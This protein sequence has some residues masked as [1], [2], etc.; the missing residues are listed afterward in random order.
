MEGMNLDSYYD[1]I[2]QIKNR[3]MNKQRDYTQQVVSKYG[4]ENVGH[5][6][7]GSIYSQLSGHTSGRYMEREG[8]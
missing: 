5:S 1:K 4:N 2:S 8:F 3:V 6:R 7:S